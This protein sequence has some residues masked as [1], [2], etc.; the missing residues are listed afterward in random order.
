MTEP[1]NLSAYYYENLHKAKSPHVLLSNFYCSL[2]NKDEK[3]SKYYVL[4]GKLVRLY[5]RERVF[6]AILD[7]YDLDNIDLDRGPYGILS[8]L[9]KKRMSK[10][11]EDPIS[12]TDLS[13]YVTRLKKKIDKQN[14]DVEK[15]K[16]AFDDN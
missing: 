8:Y 16:G 2:F 13:D 6:F 11:T 9:I 5:G 14:I 12:Y 4:M 15:Y 1:E 7:L 3:D 10:D